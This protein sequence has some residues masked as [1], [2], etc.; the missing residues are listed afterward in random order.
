MV[1][2]VCGASLVKDPGHCTNDRCGLCHALYCVPSPARIP[3][4]RG[5]VV[6]PLAPVREPRAPK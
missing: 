6:K 1:C 3:H 2:E 5:I 4:E